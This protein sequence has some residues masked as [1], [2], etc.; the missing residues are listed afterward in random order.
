MVCRSTEVFKSSLFN[1]IC[2]FVHLH[3]LLL[4]SAPIPYNSPHMSGEHALY[5]ASVLHTKDGFE[6]WLR[7][8]YT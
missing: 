1:H 4:D 2:E 8:G 7:F 3:R 5:V 6:M